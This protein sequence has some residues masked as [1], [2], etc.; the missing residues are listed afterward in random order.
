MLRTVNISKISLV[1]TIIIFASLCLNGQKKNYSISGLINDSISGDALYGVN[2]L[3]YKDSLNLNSA[4]LYGT[5]SNNFGYYIIS[6]LAVNKY[7]IIFS[8]TGYKTLVKEFLINEKDNFV[9]ENILLNPLTYNFEEIIVEGKKNKS[10]LNSE[11]DISPELLKKLPSLS[12]EIDLFKALQ[13]LPGVNKGSELSNGLYIRGGSPDQT[14]TLV[15]GAVV[16]NPSHIGNIASTFNSNAIQ[17]IKLI[18]GAFP[19][20]YGGRLGGILDIK[21]KSGTKEKEKQTIG[22]S[23]INSFL[24]FEGPIKESSS[25]IFSG[26]WM[27]YDALQKNL[28]KESKTPLYRFYDGNGKIMHNFSKSSI[29]TISAMYSNDK[30]YNSNSN[31]IDYDI[32]WKNLNLTLNWFKIDSNSLFLNSTVSYVHYEFS[33]KIGIGNSSTNSSSYFSNP[34]LSNVTFKQN[35]DIN[36]EVN[37]KLKTGLEISLHKY[38][39]MYNGYFSEQFQ[40]NEFNSNKLN[41]I[42]GAIYFQNEAEYLKDLKTNIGGR[43]YYFVERNVL[44]VEPRISF[45]YELQNYFFLKGSY[46]QVNQNLHLI[47]RNDIGL[48]T[49][50][51]YPATKN[52]SQE[53]SK[54]IVLG[55]DD[56]ID[57]GNYQLTFEGYYRDMENLYEFINSPS[58]NSIN[59]DIEKQFTKGSGE[60][61]GTEI[62]FQ[63]RNG[64]FNGWIGY[65]L[66]WSK[67]K[68]DELN[69]GKV[70]YPK[71]DRR[72]DLSV[73]VTYNLTKNINLGASFVYATGLRYS[74]P[75]SQFV[76]DPIGINGNP[77]VYLNYSKMNESLFPPYHKLDLSLNYKLFTE[78]AIFNFFVNLLNVYNRKNTYAQFVFT[79]KSDDG[80]ERTQIKRISLFPFI[81]SVGLSINF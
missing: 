48:P 25:Y 14:L 4:F 78:K 65:T 52:I 5:S 53:K 27:Y 24:S 69:F 26:R 22:I 8:H 64:D 45:S 3:V 80:T 13:M 67:R 2:I 19:S 46:A 73:V 36:I 81:P 54:Q 7:I 30:L 9:N 28:F 70:F 16:Y 32:E 57:N 51:W 35:A 79:S 59:S 50:L 41:T 77:Q 47:S 17:D 31:D 72:H 11:I 66:S 29:L 1:F 20:E 12:G 6:N 75:P 18:K 42:E 63:K 71:Y 55:L 60:S 76:F 74:L 61:Y 34:N 23:L 44:A 49:D 10:T 15:D 39:L 37:N 21:L 43:I 33:S 38:N 58:V 62:F 68:F 56:Y 40:N